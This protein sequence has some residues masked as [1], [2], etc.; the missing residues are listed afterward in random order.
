MADKTTYYSFIERHIKELP[1]DFQW[2]RTPVQIY[3]LEFISKYLRIPTPLLQA[4]YHFLLFVTSGSFHQQIGIENHFISSPSVVFVPEGEAFSIQS[5]QSN[6]KGYFILLENKAV[7]PAV[8]NM[9][10]S[11]LL[12]IDTTITLDEKMLPWLSSICNLLYKELVLNSPNRAIG[13]GLLQA[14]LH[15]L[16]DLSGNKKALSRQNEI[17]N[18][19]K[20]SVNKHFKTQKSVGFYANEFNVS[21]N[22]LNRCVKAQ[23]N[24]SCKQI[25]QE[26]SVLQS[27]IL[28]FETTKDISEICFQVGYDDPSYF[29]RIFKKVTGQTPSAFKKQIVH[30][31][32]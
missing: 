15:K 2:Q 1:P 3:P 30:G 7:S 5:I 21:E 12:T 32:S 16:K 29:S 20:Q 19:F 28:L 31:L 24:K 23:F 6:L 13:T 9:D 4:D 17:A 10:L 18:G 27:Q 11:E 25:I 26:T 22:Y 8:I 14:L